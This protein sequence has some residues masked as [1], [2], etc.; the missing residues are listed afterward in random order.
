MPDCGII[1]SFFF[2]ISSNVE[3]SRSEATDKETISQALRASSLFYTKEPLSQNRFLHA[4]PP[5]TGGGLVEM[6][7]YFN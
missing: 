3:K 1:L 2:V 7:Y 6:T 5:E 4:P